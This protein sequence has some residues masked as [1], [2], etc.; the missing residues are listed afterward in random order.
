MG[1]VRLMQALTLRRSKS[2]ACLPI[3]VQTGGSS[4]EIMKSR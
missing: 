4:I 2:V 1:E 3:D